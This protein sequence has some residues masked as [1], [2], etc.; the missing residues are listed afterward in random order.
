[1]TSERGQLKECA[2][3]GR[4]MGRL[5]HLVGGVVHQTDTGGRRN[6]EHYKRVTEH[7]AENAESP[8]GHTWRSGFK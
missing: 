7:R 1:M 8:V 5:Y 2:R 6:A 3:V 4:V